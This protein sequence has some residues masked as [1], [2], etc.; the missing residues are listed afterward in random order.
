M[1]YRKQPV[2]AMAV[3][4]DGSALALALAPQVSATRGGQACSASLA[5][6]GIGADAGDSKAVE[7]PLLG[8]VALP[9]PDSVPTAAAFFRGALGV[10]MGVAVAVAN[11]TGGGGTLLVLDAARMTWTHVLELSVACLATSPSG[12]LFAAVDVPGSST[13]ALLT[14]EARTVEGSANEDDGRSHVRSTGSLPTRVWPLPAPAD[15]VLFP[16]GGGALAVT[17]HREFVVC[18]GAP[19]ENGI[20][21]DATS[22]GDALTAGNKAAA[23]STLA[24]LLTRGAAKSMDIDVGG[25][26]V[27][28]RTKR[29]SASAKAIFA[30]TPTHELPSP[31]ELCLA[32]LDEVM[33]NE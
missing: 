32:I 24:A 1:G 7:T 25:D 17:M 10:A 12:T 27:A 22:S 19:L 26:D 13:G 11:P 18:D 6:F 9:A 5:I 16:D 15:A 31:E 28:A 20:A 4:S 2:H 33:Y 21:P 23:D 14:F 30:A 29:M 3:V 8:S